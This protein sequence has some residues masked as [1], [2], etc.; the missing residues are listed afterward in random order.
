MRLN[1]IILYIL[2]FYILIGKCLFLPIAD[3]EVKINISNIGHLFNYFHKIV[4][5][6]ITFQNYIHSGIYKNIRKVV[7]AGAKSHQKSVKHNGAIY[8]IITG[9]NQS[10]ICWQGQR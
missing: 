4:N 5:I 9:V 3:C 10:D 6:G 1:F 2:L 8:V 7:V